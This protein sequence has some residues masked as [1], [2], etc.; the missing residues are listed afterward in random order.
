MHPSCLS[1]RWACWKCSC[2]ELEI[3]HLKIAGQNWISQ[4]PRTLFC[5]FLTQ[6]VRLTVKM[7]ST[8]ARQPA[9]SQCA[10][11]RGGLC[12]WANWGRL[13]LQHCV[14][15]LCSV[16]L[17][18][19]ARPRTESW[20]VGFP[21]SFSNLSLSLLLDLLP[22]GVCSLLNPAAIYAN[23]EISLGDV[24]I[25]G[26]DYDYT[27]AQYSNLLHSMIFNTA[28][29]IL[30]EQ[31]KVMIC[32]EFPFN[33]SHCSLRPPSCACEMQHCA[34]V[35]VTH[36]TEVN[37]TFCSPWLQKGLSV[38]GMIFAVGQ[39]TMLYIPEVL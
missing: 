4:S 11:S 16:V 10:F 33:S 25:Y 7:V 17:P 21:L 8:I 12:V 30:I 26:F 39:F 23:N 22:P 3:W 14:P 6:T 32:S 24:E 27:L 34:H 2:C 36:F 1:H 5:V 19:A 18:A 28:R 29:D 37:F 20:N 9:V 35:A 13:C 31:F 38:S 15:L